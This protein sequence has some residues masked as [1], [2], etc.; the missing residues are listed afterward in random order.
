[1]LL[2]LLLELEMARNNGSYFK[3]LKKY[4]NPVLLII[5]EW[6]QLKP[7]A[8]EQH[9]IL[10]LLH[11]K[12]KK[13]STIFCP[14]YKSDGWVDQLG[15]EDSLLAEAILDRIKYDAYKINIVPVDPANSK[16]IREVYGMN[17]RLSEQT[18]TCNK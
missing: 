12:R 15:G 5:D 11:H 4:A 17:P 2:N 7:S 10:E 9:D 8:N 1:M 6:L 16:S 18:R 13:S 3:V 14:Q